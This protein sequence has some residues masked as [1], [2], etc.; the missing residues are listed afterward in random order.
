MIYRILYKLLHDSEEV[1]NRVGT[2]IFAENAPESTQGACIILR[3]LSGRAESGLDGET[4]CAMPTLQLDCYDDSATKAESLFQRV[5]NRLSGYR[6]TVEVLDIDNAVTDID[7]HEITLLRPGMFIEEPR[8]ASDRWSYRYSGD[9]E[10]YHEQ[11]V[12]TLT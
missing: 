11:S 7:V 12:P 5:R 2:R 3:N 10:V 9:F 4:D 8:D 1:R 6:G